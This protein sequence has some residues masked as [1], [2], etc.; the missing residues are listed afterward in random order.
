LGL[1][2]ISQGGVS[3]TVA[4]PR[5]IFVAALKAAASFIIL[6]HNHPSEEFRP[7]NEDIKL[8][9]K[10]VEAGKVLYIL[11]VDH[12]IITKNVYYSFCDERLI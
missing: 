3:G 5:I 12:L 10:L 7:S 9:K 1:I 4:D 6:V 8:T 11:V 2:N